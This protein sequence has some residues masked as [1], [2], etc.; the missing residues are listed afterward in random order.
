MAIYALGDVQ[1][2]YEPLQ[3][4]LEVVRFDPAQD[5]LWFAGDLINRGPHS[6][7]VLRLVYSLGESA[8]VVLGNHD[9]TLLAVAEGFKEPRQKDTFLSVL[10]AAD[11]DRLLTWLRRRP[12]LHHDAQLGFTM[13]HAGLAPQWNLDQVL[14]CAAEVESALHGSD[15]RNFLAHMYGSEPRVW[16]DDLQGMERL[17]FIVNC[18]TRIRFC[19]AEGALSFDQKGP[20]GSQPDG[21]WPWFKVPG[22]RNADL[23]VIFGHWSSQGFYR[24]PGIYALDSGCVWG[25]KLTALRL[26]G[27]EEVYS[28]DCSNINP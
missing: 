1:G 20:P 15:Y 25:N 28:V 10:D 27:P 23:N 21:L 16:R 13:V 14:S 17:R 18:L 8:V 9:L 5:T 24:E 11:R 2:C 3:R 7:E 6:L 26:D 12:I 4:L 19:T 22:R